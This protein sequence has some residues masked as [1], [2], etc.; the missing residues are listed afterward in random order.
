MGAGKILIKL[1]GEDADL[2]LLTMVVKPRV[3]V[4]PVIVFIPDAVHTV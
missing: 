3:S 4:F 1:H 2:Y